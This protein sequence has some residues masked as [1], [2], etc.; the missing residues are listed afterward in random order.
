MSKKRQTIEELIEE[1]LVPEE[2]QPYEVPENWVW[3]RLGSVFQ[4]GKEQIQPTGNEKYIG[5]EHLNKGGG[6]LEIGNAEGIKSKKVIFKTND[7]LYGKLR[8]YLNKHAH[9]NF[10]GVASTD[11]LV[12]R[13]ENITTSKLLNMYFN[14]PHVLRYTNEN[15]NGINLPRVSPKSMDVLSF[16]LPPLN[17]QKRIAKKVECLLN[18]LEEAKQLVEEAKETF[19]LRRKSMLKQALDGKLTKKWRK[20]ESDSIS[21][22]EHIQNAYDE[23][24]KTYDEQC[25]N[26]K[27]K[28]KPR[29][30]RPEIFKHFS[31]VDKKIEGL[32]KWIKT[33]FIH[34]CVLQR[35][36][37]LPVHAR[38]EGI[39]PIVSAGGIIDYHIEYR[40]KGPGVT[41]GRSGTIGSV[42]YIEEDYWALNTS[43]YVDHFN[44]NIPKFVYYYLLSFDFKSYSSS[45]AVPTLNR[46]N[47]FDAE[48]KIPPIKEQEIIVEMLDNFFNK[49]AEAYGLIEKLEENL[50]KLKQ[51]ILSKA[52][53]GELGTNEPTEESAIELLK[54]VLQEKIK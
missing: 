6:I 16:P 7:V 53:R 35:G 46:N 9:V 39:Y 33:T 31:L 2:E 21:A 48:V 37:D 43:L 32:P 8:P 22:Y 5:L 18:K 11:I 52:F 44:G 26:A 3:T 15:S 40:V 41:T 45:T 20:D 28:N 23:L 36:Y 54:E 12:Y 13:N 38:E 25:L 30:K 29:P 24:K 14:L 51:S 42:F 50:M 34:L 1:A 19:E 47:F 17:E 49:E 4:Q 27:E 10:E